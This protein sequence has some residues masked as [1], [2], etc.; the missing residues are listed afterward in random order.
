MPIKQGLR[1]NVSLVL[2]T[3]LVWI[4]LLVSG[5]NAAVVSTSDMLVEHQQFENK[6]AARDFLNRDEVQ[7]QMLDLGVSPQ[8]VDL[9]INSMTTLEL[10][11]LN[12]S[13][14]D[15][16]A[17][18]GVLGVALTVFIVFVITDVIGATDIFPFIRPVNR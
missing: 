2:S 9:R 4:T 5:A 15:A 18:A 8:D 3:L 14:Q 11:Q 6:Q 7:Q 1:R 10:A 16:P 12:A 17:G 13:L